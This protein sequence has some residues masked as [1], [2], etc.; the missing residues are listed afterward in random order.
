MRAV[1]APST[2]K[3]VTKAPYSPPALIILYTGLTA[4]SAGVSFDFLGFE[5]RPDDLSS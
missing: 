3:Y 5:Q 4:A 1:P 2:E